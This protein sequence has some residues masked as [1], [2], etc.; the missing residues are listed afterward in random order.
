MKK[1]AKTKTPKTQPATPAPAPE[2]ADPAEHLEKLRLARLFSEILMSGDFEIEFPDDL[3]ATR[4]MDRVAKL[5][6]RVRQ[7]EERLQAAD[8]GAPAPDAPAGRV[9]VATL[10][11]GGKAKA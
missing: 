7:L 4:T 5:E 1:N 3:I 11:K 8:P 6:A 9:D 2:G 10:A